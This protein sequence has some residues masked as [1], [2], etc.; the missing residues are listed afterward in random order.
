[1]EKIMKERDYT[2]KIKI[3]NRQDNENNMIKRRLEDNGKEDGVTRKAQLH[4]CKKSNA[5][6]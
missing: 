1:M 3:L 4:K 6:Y 5:T 2:G